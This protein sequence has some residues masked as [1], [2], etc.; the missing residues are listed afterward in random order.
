MS[1]TLHSSK[2]NVL[3][4]SE[5]I[6]YHKTQTNVRFESLTIVFNDV[7]AFL[8]QCSCGTRKSSLHNLLSE[9]LTQWNAAGCKTLNYDHYVYTY[10]QRLSAFR[11][12]LYDW[13]Y[14]ISTSFS[15]FFPKWFS[16][17]ALRNFQWTKLQWYNM[18]WNLVLTIVDQRNIHCNC[19]I[20]NLFEKR[21][22]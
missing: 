11:V 21:L 9:L 18:Y 4:G 5:L 19:Y 14:N 13:L 17:A 15:H 7:I 10:Y 3:C 6:V 12:L 22:Q 2:P 16:H 1:R 20:K 8:L